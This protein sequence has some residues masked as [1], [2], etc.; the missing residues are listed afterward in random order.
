[1]PTHWLPVSSSSSDQ[2]SCSPLDRLPWPWVW[3]LISPGCKSLFLASI[4]AAPAGAFSPGRPIAAIVSPFIRMSA[5]AAVRLAMSRSLP[6]RIIVWDARAIVDTLADLV[7]DFSTLHGA[8]RVM[9]H[10]LIS[11]DN[12][13]DL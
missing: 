2:R 6:P 4:A 1:M 5:G 7:P 13:I 3:A 12:H 11:G 9:Q 10:K 8:T